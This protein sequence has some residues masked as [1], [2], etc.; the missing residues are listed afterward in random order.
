MRNVSLKVK[1]RWCRQGFRDNRITN[2]AQS[3]HAELRHHF[4]GTPSGRSE[5]LPPGGCASLGL[6]GVR[7]FA[8]RLT[9][10]SRE[11]WGFRC[12]IHNGQGRLGDLWLFH[13]ITEGNYT[14]DF[15]ATAPSESEWAFDG[16]PSKGERSS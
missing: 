2:P 13:R 16:H 1:L 9:P 6:W 12:E 10:R 4:D 3:I 7:A 8:R 5:T 15:G 11:I 14:I